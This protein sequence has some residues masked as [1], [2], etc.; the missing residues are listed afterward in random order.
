MPACMRKDRARRRAQLCIISATKIA[1]QAGLGKR[2]NMITQGVFFKLCGVT[3][4]EVAGGLFKG[5]IK[6]GTG[7]RATSLCR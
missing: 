5:S 2:F 4:Y 7:R 6:K 1:I 3:P